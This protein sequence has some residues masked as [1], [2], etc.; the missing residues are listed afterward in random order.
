MKKLW[1]LNSR[2]VKSLPLICFNI[3]TDLVVISGA[4]FVIEDSSEV[5]FVRFGVILRHFIL[6]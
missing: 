5:L 6:N 2:K 3:L 1:M 4:V